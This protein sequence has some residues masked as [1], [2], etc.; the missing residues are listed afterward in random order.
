MQDTSEEETRFTAQE[1]ID[2]ETSLRS[3]RSA[4]ETRWEDIARYVDPSFSGSMSNP[5]AHPDLPTN[6]DAQIDSTAQVANR[7]FAAILGAILTPPNQNWHKLTH[8]D[9]KIR[10]N[11]DVRGWFEAVNDCLYNERYSPSAGFD[12][13]NR[14][15]FHSVGLFGFGATY[16]TKRD[17]GGLR[18]RHIPLGEAV[19]GDNHQGII[20][21]MYRKFYLT[22]RQAIQKWGLKCPKTIKEEIDENKNFEFL[23]CIRPRR[24]KA[25]DVFVESNKRFEAHYIFVDDKTILASYGYNVF[26]VAV[27]R[28]DVALN[29][30]YGEGPSGTIIAGIR[31]LNEMAR[32]HI[33]QLQRAADPSYLVPD[34]SILN[35]LNMRNGAINFGGVSVDGRALVHTLPHGDIVVSIEAIKE[36]QSAVK[37]PY[38]TDLFQILS[39][40]RVMTATQVIQLA[41]ERGYLLAPVL[42]GLQ[43]EYLGGL[44]A[45]EISI[46]E[47]DGRLPEKPRGLGSAVPGYLHGDGGSVEYKNP[48]S[49]MIHAPKTA[50]F[51]RTIEVATATANATG[52]PEVMDNFDVDIA[53]QQIAE[54]NDVPVSWT[55]SDAKKQGIRLERQKEVQKAQQIQAMTGVA[56]LVNAQ[57]NTQKARNSARGDV[58]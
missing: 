32:T 4:L 30:V 35:S 9:K 57:A 38:L 31:G 53:I 19:Y 52:H 1:I 34:E 45:R 6:T 29:S 43:S 23:H 5:S 41:Q 44:I 39:D 24:K 49:S 42:A 54:I 16:I 47:D 37:E 21:S 51:L 25:G 13:Q 33:Q 17:G 55:N 27:A 14:R 20:D 48:L 56:S 3:N 26:P 12:G 11:R 15:T 40:P 2:A 28:Y 58:S 22:K 8:Y 7:R 10:E 50:G 36:L 46:L 18:Y